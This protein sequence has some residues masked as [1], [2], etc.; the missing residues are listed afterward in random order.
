MPYPGKGNFSEI[1]FVLRTRVPKW[2][3]FELLIESERDMFVKVVK[4]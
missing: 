4:T 2:I 3:D 1:N